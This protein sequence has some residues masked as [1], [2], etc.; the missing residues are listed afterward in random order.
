MRWSPT[1]EERVLRR[2]F[3]LALVL[4]VT[5]V[6]VVTRSLGALAVFIGVAAS[7]AAHEGGHLLAARACGVRITEFMVGFGPRL[8]M[9]RLRGTEVS[10]RLLPFAG[11]AVKLHDEDEQR[12]RHRSWVFVAAAGPIAN[13]AFGW[14]LLFG[15]AAFLDG[16]GVVEAA[17]TATGQTRMMLTL[18]AETVQ[19]LPELVAGN[20][21]GAVGGEIP[22]DTDRL[23]SPVSMAQ[24]GNDATE[25]GGA[26]ML[27]RLVAVINIGLGVMNLLPIPPLDGSL[28]TLHTL[29][30][31]AGRVTGRRVRVPKVLFRSVAYGFTG[32]VLVALAAAMVV[33]LAAPIDAFG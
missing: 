22:A 13:L 28:I 14:A 25:A 19:R 3:R 4:G 18:T 7:I 30:G 16:D 24:L 5:A 8:W 9:R 1:D 21:G 17:P 33:D 29:E 11:G 10:L 32:I 23:L 15:A 12:L 31:A 20:I 27:L 6:V 2:P 26:A